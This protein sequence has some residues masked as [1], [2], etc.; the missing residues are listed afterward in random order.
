MFTKAKLKKTENLQDSF[1]TE[2]LTQLHYKLLNYV[3]NNCN[4]RFVMCHSYN[5]KIRMKESAK[6]GDACDSGEDESRGDWIAISSP[7]DLFTLG[8]DEID[9][10][11]LNYQP[12][13]INRSFL[14]AVDA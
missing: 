13:F 14:V 12:L 8:F 7:D 1:T 6:T 3:K 11:A 9:F 10:E 2:D 4:N 5:G